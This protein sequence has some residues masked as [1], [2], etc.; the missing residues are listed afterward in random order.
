MC[1]ALA[2]LKERVTRYP[3]ARIVLNVE[4]DDIRNRNEGGVSFI[5]FCEKNGIV[6]NGDDRPIHDL[7]DVIDG[8]IALRFVS[9]GV[10]AFF[11]HQ[12]E[13]THYF[14]RENME[15]LKLI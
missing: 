6:W 3:N 12:Q 2:E 13:T 7:D 11:T 5:E 1:R 15:L 9:K 4:I 10:R 8:R 14:D